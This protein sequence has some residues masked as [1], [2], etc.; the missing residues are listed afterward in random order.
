M[1]SADH[2]LIGR[3]AWA[4]TNQDRRVRIYVTAVD[5]EGPNGY[6]VWGYRVSTKARQGAQTSYPR[7]YFVPAA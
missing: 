1:T 5:A 2:P 6:D 3:N 7:R 4:L